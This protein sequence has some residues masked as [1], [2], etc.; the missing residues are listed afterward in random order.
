MNVL[1]YVSGYL[2]FQSVQLLSFPRGDDTIRLLM[3]VLLSA[4][5]CL[6][7]ICLTIQSCSQ[8]TGKL[9]FIAS[10]LHFNSLIRLFGSVNPAAILMHECKRNTCTKLLGTIFCTSF[11]FYTVIVHICYSIFSYFCF[12]DP[13]FYINFS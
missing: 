7:S 3:L 8:N 4:S 1:D 11:P 6:S 10:T 5:P 13:L 9:F 2:Y 12:V